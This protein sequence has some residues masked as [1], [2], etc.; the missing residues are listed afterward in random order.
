[1]KYLPKEK[2][3]VVTQKDYSKRIIFTPGNLKSKGNLVQVVT[4]KPGIAQRP[5]FHQAQTS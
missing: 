4:I 2:G 5:H 3:R 1:M